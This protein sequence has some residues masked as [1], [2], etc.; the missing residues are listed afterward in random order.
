MGKRFSS[1]LVIS[2]T[3]F[4]YHHPDTVSFLKALKKKYK[5]DKVVH[6]G[7]ELDFHALSFH[8]SDPDLLSPGNELL[9]GISTISP[10]YRLFP[11]VDL[12]ESNHGSMVYRKAKYHGIPREVFKSYRKVLG[13]PMGWKWHFDRRSSHYE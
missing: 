13:A 10:L 2:D 1:I 5:P 9:A 12:I 6:I 8:P 11:D 3:H 4:P 7:D